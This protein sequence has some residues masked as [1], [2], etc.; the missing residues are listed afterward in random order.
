MLCPLGS[1]LH[2]SWSVR[3]RQHAA[4]RLRLIA[5]ALSNLGATPPELAIQPKIGRF[6]E[7]IEE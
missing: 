3:V 5:P 6:V 1:F 4:A 7:E 2:L